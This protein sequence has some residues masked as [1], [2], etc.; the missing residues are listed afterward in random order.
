MSNNESNQSN[1]Q[2][3]GENNNNTST[4][5]A[6]TTTAADEEIIT[7]LT[8]A[9]L[10]V[11][12]LRKG[13]QIIYKLPDNMNLAS[14][15]QQQRDQLMQEIQK[16]HAATMA[17]AARNTN[18]DN[19]AQPQAKTI[20]PKQN[21]IAVAPL[22]PMGTMSP[23]AAAGSGSSSNNTGFPGQQMMMMNTAESDAL[24]ETARKL[25]EEYELDQ[26]RQQQHHQQLQLLQLQMDPN[27]RPNTEVKTTRKYVKTGKYSKKKMN[28]LQQQS[29]FSHQFQPQQQSQPQI[30][31][32][33]S[34][35]PGMGQL[36]P[37]PPPLTPSSSSQV[38]PPP[39]MLNPQQLLAFQQQLAQA[40]TAGGTGGSLNK[41]PIPT[42][43]KSILAK[44][45]PEEEKHHQ[46]IKKRI[47]ESMMSDR[48]AVLNPDYETPFKSKDDVI[49]RLLPYHIYQYPKT[50]LDINKIPQD[51][52]D[53]ATMDIFKSQ[54]E[55]FEKFSNISV[56]IATGGGEKQ[57]R[58]LLERHILAD[59]RQRLTEEQAR[60]AAEQAAFQQEMIRIQEQ[61]RLAAA[62]AAAAQAETQ[63][64]AQALAQAQTQAQN[65]SSP[66]SPGNRTNGLAQ[67]T[68]L[69]QNPQFQNQYNQ[70]PPEMQQILGNKEQ[71]AALIE[72]HSKDNKL[73]VPSTQPSSSSSS[74]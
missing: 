15:N 26:Q 52:Q 55:L 47:Y 56:K 35:P 68:A 41:P 42:L 12:M 37:P 17:A 48:E 46:E 10:K 13:D 29:Q 67:A 23:I 32:Q 45:L 53:H 21:G 36:P 7:Q 72:Q 4:T 58:I 74:K 28:Q 60:V 51:R 22:Q 61:Q 73:F 20:A 25:R 19:T 59:Q 8:L 39:P 38:P 62:A 30:Q 27:H 49:K 6:T 57:L 24:Q 16:L 5:A 71:L 44:R 64:Q 18:T 2:I 3:N 65:T 50:D 31:Q 1:P 66:V 9:G 69:L 40:A 70:L 54:A 43:P 33:Q 11:I 34:L 63:R 14:I